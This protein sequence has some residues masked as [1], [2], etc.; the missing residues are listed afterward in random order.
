MKHSG[1]VPFILAGITFKTTQNTEGT[2]IMLSNALKVCIHV[3]MR[4]WKTD[5][6]KIYS[7]HLQLD[8]N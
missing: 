5:Q 3:Q 7:G 1:L 2:T 4:S 6:H 8:L